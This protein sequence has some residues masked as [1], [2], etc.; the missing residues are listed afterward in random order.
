MNAW[1]N[2]H[3]GPSTLAPEDVGRFGSS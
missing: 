2:A 3:V 1:L